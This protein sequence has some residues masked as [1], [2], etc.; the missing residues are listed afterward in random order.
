[1]IK[2]YK[3]DSKNWREAVLNEVLCQANLVVCSECNAPIR[4][5]YVCIHCDNEHGGHDELTYFEI[6]EALRKTR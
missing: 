3:I 6:E 1:M 5:G 4:E 2:K